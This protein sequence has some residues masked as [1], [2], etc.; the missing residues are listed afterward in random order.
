VWN[1]EE[2]TCLWTLVGHT[3]WITRIVYSSQGDLIVTAS[4][5]K[6]VRLWD[7]T[8]GQCRAVIEG[9]QSAVSDIAWIEA[10]GVN[11]LATGCSDGLVGMWQ[12][13]VDENQC[14]VSQSWITTK[15]ELNVH[16]ATIE[17]VQ[18]L[19]QLNNQLLKQRGSVG[20]PT[21]RL[22]EANKT[23]LGMA[24]EVSNSKIS[25]NKAEE[26]PALTPSLPAEQ[27]EQWIEQANRLVV[28]M[29]SIGGYR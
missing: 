8:S 29:K 18:G 27:L 21:H 11:Y 24:S 4:N 28:S 16:G 9:F 13:L 20:E 1:L 7:V 19:S 2:G 23:L 25:S 6:S 22:S 10:A 17:D 3:D 14:H 26:Y 15:G 12:V 5:D